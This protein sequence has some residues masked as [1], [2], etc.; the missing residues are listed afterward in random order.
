MSQS[1]S[2]QAS[3]VTSVP[4]QLKFVSFTN[5]RLKDYLAKQPSLLS[6]GEAI[7]QARIPF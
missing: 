6:N 4:I 7:W 2:S 3:I 5:K 1:S